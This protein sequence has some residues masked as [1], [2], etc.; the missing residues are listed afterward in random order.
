LPSVPLSSASG[1]CLIPKLISGYSITGSAGAQTIVIQTT[2][3]HNLAENDTVYLKFILK[4]IPTAAADAV[5]TVGVGGILGPNSFKVP[6]PT[7]TT[8][9]NGMQGAASVN[10]YPLK[11]SQWNRSGTVALEFSTWGIGIQSNLNQNPLNSPTVFNFFYPDYQ[12]PGVIANAGMTTPEFQLTNDSN[13]MNLTNFITQ[14]V[15]TN[16]TGS[17]GSYFHFVGSQAITMD[18]SSYMTPSQTSNAGIPALVDKLG[19]LLTGGNLSSAVKTT[20]SNYL[21]STNPVVAP[22]NFPYTTPTNSEMRDRVRAIV[23]LICTSAEYA[24]QK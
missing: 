13:T 18:Y 3:N 8:I 4:N 16:T 24:I 9:T 14:G 10:V 5:Y 2:G 11:G 6:V 21:T 20:I 7:A 17:I 23:H 12:Y 1:S 15:L 19:I 22:V